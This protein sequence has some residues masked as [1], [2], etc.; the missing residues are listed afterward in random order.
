MQMDNCIRENKNRYVF[1]FAAML[2]ELGIVREVIIGFLLV[3]HTH[4]SIDQ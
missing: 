1:S 4:D 2:V 3:G